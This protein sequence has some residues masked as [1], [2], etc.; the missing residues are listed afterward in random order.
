MSEDCDEVLAIQYAAATPEL[1]A[2]DPEDVNRSRRLGRT[3]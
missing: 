2:S 1:L 3:N